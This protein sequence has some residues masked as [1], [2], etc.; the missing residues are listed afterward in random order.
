MSEVQWGI[1]KDYDDDL[2]IIEG[3][4]D[5]YGGYTPV[6]KIEQFGEFGIQCANL[7]AS[8]PQLLGALQS[9][10]KAVNDVYY[11]GGSVNS[12]EFVEIEDE[13]KVVVK[14]ALGE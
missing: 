8:A 12:K 14:K 7:I 9:L 6:A 2:Y 11:H 5:Q 1:H 3:E 4:I 13:A 10:L